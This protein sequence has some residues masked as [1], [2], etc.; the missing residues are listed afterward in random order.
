MLQFTL[1]SQSSVIILTIDNNLTISGQKQQ[2]YEE[3]STQ[4]V[5]GTNKKQL[6]NETF[7]T[8]KKSTDKEKTCP[9]IQRS[10][11]QNIH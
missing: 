3:Q 4:L 10:E 8:S 11:G 7:F 1:M 2:Q 9:M 5:T 6:T